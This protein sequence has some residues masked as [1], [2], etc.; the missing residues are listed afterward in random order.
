[1]KY[2]NMNILSK[3]R[4]TIYGISIFLIVFCHS[5]LNFENFLLLKDIKSIGNFGVDVFL[6]LSGI[7]LYYS[8][9][10]NSSIKQFYSRRLKRVLLPTIIICVPYYIVED[11]IVSKNGLLMFLYDISGIS[12]SWFCFLFYVLFYSLLH[13]KTKCLYALMF[14]LCDILTDWQQFLQQFCSVL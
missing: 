6:L 2:Y 4:S 7:S 12:F 8:F 14:F 1:M 5:S 13:T 10:K 11:F 9:E 3:N